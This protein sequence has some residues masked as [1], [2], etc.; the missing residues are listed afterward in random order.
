[1][2]AFIF[3]LFARKPQNTA[4]KNTNN[5]RTKIARHFRKSTRDQGPTNRPT[6]Q[7]LHVQRLHVW[8]RELSSLT[9]EIR[10]GANRPGA[11]ETHVSRVNQNVAGRV[12]SGQEVFEIPRGWSGRVNMLSNLAGRVGSG[13]QFFKSCGSGRIRSRG[14]QNLAGQVGSGQNSRGSGRVT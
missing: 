8:T 4:K 9:R 7:R 11:H 5:K 3:I 13:Q 14:F 12:G 2:C 6:Y 10:H 1:M